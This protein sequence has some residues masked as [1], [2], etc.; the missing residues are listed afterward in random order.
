MDIND[1]WVVMEIDKSATITLISRT[2][3]DRHWQRPNKPKLS[4][5]IQKLVTYTGE[6]ITPCSTCE[7]TVIYDNQQHHLLL[8]VVPRS[9]PTLLGWK[10]LEVIDLSWNR[11]HQ[12]KAV[13]VAPAVEDIIQRYPDL[14]KDELGELRNYTASLRVDPK[15]KSNLLQ[16]MLCTLCIAG[17][18]GQRAGQAGV[19]RDNRTY[20]KYSEWA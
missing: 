7:I 6:N 18:G 10:W 4:L 5:I 14:F 13:N 1:R 19:F 17:K 12:L 3:F 8:V 11:I 20:T 9:G 16:S 15:H 2:V